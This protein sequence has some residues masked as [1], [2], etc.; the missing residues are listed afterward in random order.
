MTGLT[1]TIVTAI[2]LLVCCTELV[3]PLSCTSAANCTNE[4]IANPSQFV[5]CVNNTCVCNS[6]FQSDTGMC[7][8]ARC[9]SYNIAGDTCSSTAQKW[10]AALVISILL[11]GTG[12]ANFY[13][14]RYEF[15][16]PQLVLFCFIMI[17]PCVICV[18]YCC[19]GCDCGDV[20]RVC[21][22]VVNF[23]LAIIL[24]IL[25]LCLASW[26]VADAVIFI[27]NERQD[28]NGCGLARWL[29]KFVCSVFVSLAWFCKICCRVI[30]F[31]W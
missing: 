30:V 11:G 17:L 13:I 20:A 18:L 1:C 21:G 29:T 9:Y 10:L 26:W 15:A 28:G 19:T 14:G 8:V 6:C 24:L 5:S 22:L 12:A 25:N 16:I 7:T 2:L 27:L 4:V 3:Q 31:V 23:I